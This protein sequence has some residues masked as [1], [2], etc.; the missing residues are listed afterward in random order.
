VARLTARIGE[1][2]T[3]I[4]ALAAALMP[5]IGAALGSSLTRADLAVLAR[6]ADP[7]ALRAVSL[8]RLTAAIEKASIGHSGQDKNRAGRGR[9][10]ARLAGGGDPALG[11]RWQLPSEQR[12]GQRGPLPGSSAW[13]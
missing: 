1:H 2:K 11:R 3:R 10:L 6:W 4:R 8:R 12:T 5:T 13:P 7:R 9:L